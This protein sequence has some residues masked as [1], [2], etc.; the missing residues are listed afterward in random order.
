MGRVN[1]SWIELAFDR[2]FAVIRVLVI[3]GVLLGDF[4]LVQRPSGARDWGLATAGLVLCLA[5]GKWTFSA[6]LAQSGLLVAAHALGT[7]VVSSLKA[8]AAVTLFE[9]AVRQSARRLAAGAVALALAVAAN[10]LADLPGDLLSVLYKMGI[11][12]GLPLLMGAYVRVTRNAARHARE[13][14]EQQELRAEQQLLAARAAE[15]TAIARELHDLVAHHVSSM[16]LRVGVARHVVAA[17]SNTDPR[18]TDVL[19]DLHSSGNTA[20]ADLRRLVAVLRIP[21]GTGPDTGSLVTPGALPA[22]LES[23]VERSRRTG[24]AVTASVD[25]GVG[26]LDAVRGL[27][28]LRLAQEGLAN[29]VKHA[30]P[31]AHAEFAVRVADDV[32]HMTVHDD[33]AGRAR[34]PAPGPS[35]HGLTGMRERVD[36]LGGRLDAGPTARGWRLTAEL[37]AIASTLEPQ[38]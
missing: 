26:R 17:T 12:A 29:A 10:R 30:G 14:A 21:D 25:P 1:R 13:H 15:R 6:L 37:P 11:V 20:L 4:L 18:I 19:D 16:V 8:L 27:A 34:P 5:S 2:R 24:L 22:A 7:G 35:G 36:L 9:L 28:V 38:P 31:G 32:I 33:G 23:V 3:T